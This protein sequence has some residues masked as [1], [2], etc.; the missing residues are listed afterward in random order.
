[1]TSP[2]YINALSRAIS[3]AANHR[4]VRDPRGS[5]GGCAGGDARQAQHLVP[6]VRGQAARGRREEP[7]VYDNGGAG[8]CACAPG[9][10]TI[11]FIRFF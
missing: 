2:V 1:M 10:Y 7:A 4:G 11:Y 3:P 8:E 9:N 5:T 6:R